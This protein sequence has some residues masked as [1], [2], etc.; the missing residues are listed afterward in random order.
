MIQW[1]EKAKLIENKYS[2]W[3][4]ALI[5][6]AQLRHTQEGRLHS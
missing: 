2:K 6:K 4:S 3:Y 1:P 5:T